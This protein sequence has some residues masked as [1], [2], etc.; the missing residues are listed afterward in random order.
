MLDDPIAGGRPFVV[1][2]FR[3]FQAMNPSKTAPSNLALADTAPSCEGLSRRTL[4]HSLAGM[5]A[6]ALLMPGGSAL[7]ASR[8]RPRLGVNLAGAEFDAI[9]GNWHWPNADNMRYY[10]QKGFNIFRI[11]FLWQRL[12]PQP[13]GPLLESALTGLDAMVAAINAAGAV[14]VLDSHDYGHVNKAIIG[15]PGSGVTIDDFADFWG[16]MG[17]RYRQRS[18]VWYNLMN[19]PHDMPPQLNLDMQNAAVSAIRD[20]GARSKVL[21]S[22]IAW[23]G[24]HSWLSSGNGQVMLGVNDPI[25]NFGFDIHQYLN[26][27]YGGGAGPVMPGS[28]SQSLIGVTQ[29]ARQN[30]MK[31]FV[32]EFGCDPLPEFMKEL[33]DLL[34]FITANPDVF[35]G[36]TYFAGGGTWGR[37][38]ASA[39]PVDGVEKPQLSLM[40]HYL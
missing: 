22:G 24:G 39:D 2:I 7:A 5:G 16:R 20:A 30:G 11:P 32:G 23:T 38:R 34:N 35:I 6:G 10:L 1:P 29:W 37:N 25:G 27:G 31:L 8:S 12:Q 26:R 4:L 33:T 36:A 28:G 21:F 3:K 13:G 15:T 9:G 19:E 40:E 17:A 18:L 14:A